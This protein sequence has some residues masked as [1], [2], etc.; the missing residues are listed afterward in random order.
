MSRKRTTLLIVIAALTTTLGSATSVAA[1]N[2]KQFSYDSGF[3]TFVDTEVCR[4]PAWTGEQ[5]DVNATEREYG[6]GESFFDN[7]GSFVRGIAHVYHDTTISANGK[8]IVERDTFTVFF[9]ADGSRDVGL[10]GHIQGPGGIVLRDAGQIVY[11][12]AGNPEY[13]IGPHPQF[14]GASFCPGLTL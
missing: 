12:A 4:T 14:A 6:F 11:D 9:S 8:T 5:F 10:F 3:I 13:V 2:P 1:A 7:D